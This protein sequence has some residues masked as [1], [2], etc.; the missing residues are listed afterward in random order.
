MIAVRD[1]RL[2]EAA[3][4][5]GRERG[6]TVAETWTYRASPLSWPFWDSGMGYEER[7]VS[8]RKPL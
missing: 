8:L 7:S 6:A 1:A 5:W 2:V 3:E 4:A